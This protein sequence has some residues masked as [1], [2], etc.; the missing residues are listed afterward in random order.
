MAV[1]YSTDYDDAGADTDL[2]DYTGGSPSVVWTETNTSGDQEIDDS[3]TRV[4]GVATFGDRTSVVTITGAPNDEYSVTA[5]VRAEGSNFVRIGVVGRGADDSTNGYYA[6]LATNNNWE[7]WRVVGGYTLLDSGTF[8]VARN[9]DYTVTLTLTNDS[10]DTVLQVTIDDTDYGG[11]P[12]FTDADANDIETG[13]P[14]LY[15]LTNTAR[16]ACFISFEVDDL[17]A[18]GVPLPAWMRRRVKLVS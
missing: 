12:T 8:T 2:N 10:G 9:T 17:A 16:E 18:A 3:Q 15:H 13:E 6:T 14:G 7:L 4:E 5:V 1:I 11:T